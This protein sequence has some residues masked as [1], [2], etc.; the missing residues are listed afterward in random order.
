MKKSLYIYIIVILTGVIIEA[1]DLTGGNSSE[2]T[3]SNLKLS[4][5]NLVQNF[6]Y[7]YLEEIDSVAADYYFEMQKFGMSIDIYGFDWSSA[8]QSV[9]FSLFPAA[10]AD[11]AP[12]RSKY[13]PAL[14]SI[15]SDSA[16]VVHDAT[17]AAGENITSLFL[18]NYQS[19]QWTS[20]L[21]M[22]ENFGEWNEYDPILLRFDTIPTEA[23]N[24]RFYV[25]VTMEN[26]DEFH[27][28]TPVIKTE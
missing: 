28:K 1:C 12:I 17:Y 21:K 26:G 25:K 5:G 22:L 16:I 6:S 7:F 19:N 23:L 8:N 10:Y 27:L 15:S 24:Q 4:V 13:K 9:P 2:K 18:A 20:I 11:P 14:I 3:I